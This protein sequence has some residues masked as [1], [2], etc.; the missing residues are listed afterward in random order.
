MFG[1]FR[2]GSCRAFTGASGCA[3]ASLGCWPMGDRERDFSKAGRVPIS[4]PVSSRPATATASTSYSFTSSCSKCRA[5]GHAQTFVAPEETFKSGR[6]SA[7]T[8]RFQDIPLQ[9]MEGENTKSWYTVPPSVAA[10]VNSTVTPLPMAYPSAAVPAAPTANDLMPRFL[11]APVVPSQVQAEAIRHTLQSWPMPPTLAAG[12]AAAPAPAPAAGFLQRATREAIHTKSCHVWWSDPTGDMRFRNGYNFYHQYAQ[13]DF[14]VLDRRMGTLEELRNLVNEAHAL[15]MY[16]MNHMVACPCEFGHTCVVANDYYFEGHA[17]SQATWRFHEDGGKREYKLK[18]RATQ[19]SYFH[20]M[21]WCGDALWQSFGNEP[22]GTLLNMD[23]CGDRC[24]SDP[25]CFFFLYK[26]DPGSLSTYHC[27]GFNSCSSPTPYTDGQGHVYKKWV[28]P[29]KAV[30][31]AADVWCGSHLWQ[32]Y[33]HEATG[34]LVNQDTCEAACASDASCQFYLWKDDPAANTR[35]HCAGFGTCAEADQTPFGD[36]DGS[37]IFQKRTKAERDKDGLYHTPA[38]RQP[39]ADFWYSNAWDPAAQYN[40]TLYG[41]WGESATDTGY[42]TYIESDFHHNGDLIDYHDPWEINLGKIYGVMDDLRLEQDRVQQKYIAMTKALIE[43]ADVDGYR[44]DTPMQVPLNFYKAW[45]PAMRAHAKTLG[46]DRFGI[47]GEFFVSAER[48]ATMTGRGRD[49]TMYGQDRFIDDIATLK[50]GIVYPYYWYVF[51][52]MVYQRPEYADGLP[53]AYVEENKMI[54]TY[55][56]TTNRH[57]YSMWT[58]CNN[59]DNWR[60]QS[61][62]GKPHF[63]MCLAVITFWPGVPLHYAGDEQDFDTPGSALDGWAREELSTSLAWRAVRTRESGNPADGDNFDMTHP[64]YLYIGR[65]SALRRAH[66][67][68]FGAEEC[69]EVQYPSYATP[70]VLVFLRGC[71][72][73]SKVLVFANFHTTQNR[74]ASIDALPWASGT[75]LTDCIVSHDPAEVIVS[76]GSVSVSLGPL[77]A[78]AFVENVAAVPPSITEVMPRH[79]STIDTQETNLTITLRFDRTVDSS[80]VSN[81]LLDQTSGGFTCMGDTCTREIAMASLA[82]GHHTL[83]VRAGSA[84]ADGM[85]L[86][87]SFES[88][89]LLDRQQGAISKPIHEQ[90]GLIC[91]FGRELCHNAV[92]ATLYRAQNVGGNWSEWMP[93]ASTTAWQAQLDVPVLVQYFSQLSAGFIVGDCLAS[94]GRRCHVSWHDRMFLRGELNDWGGSDEGHMMLISSYT[95]ASNITLSKFIRARFTPTNDWSKSYG[96]HPVRELLYNVPT[97]D[98][99]H[100]TFDIVPTKSGSE[101]CREWM[102]NRSLWSEHE[103]IA[104]GAEFAI[105]LWLSPFCTAA[106]PQC[107]PDPEAKWQ[108]HSYQTGQ[109]A[110][111]CASVGSEG[112]FEYSTNDQSEEMSSCVDQPVLEASFIVAVQIENMSDFEPKSN[113]IHGSLIAG[114]YGSATPNVSIADVAYMVSAEFELLNWTGALQAA[115]TEICGILTMR[116]STCSSSGAE[117]I[118]AEVRTAE[119]D[120]AGALHGLAKD[121]Q[122]MQHLLRSSSDAGGNASLRLLMPP[123]LELRLLTDVVAFASDW[124]APDLAPNVSD[125]TREFSSGYSR[126]VVLS[127]LPSPLASTTTTTLAPASSAAPNVSTTSSTVTS[128][129]SAGTNDCVDLA[130]KSAGAL[131]GNL[132]EF[133]IDGVQVEMTPGRGLSVVVLDEHGTS[134]SELHVFDTGFEAGGSAPLATLLNSLSEG[135]GVMIAA[136]DDASDNLT[137]AARNAIKQLGATQIDNLGYRGSY[138]LIGVKGRSAVAER[139]AASGE[140]HVQVS[141]RNSWKPACAD[142]TSSLA[143]AGDPIALRVRSAGAA[144]GNF[145]EFYV[146]GALVDVVAGR[147][148]TVVSLQDG[149]VETHVFDT[150]FEGLGSEGLVRFLQV[151]PYGTLVMVAAMDDATDNLTAEAK[152]AI[153]GLGASEIRSLSYRGSYALIGVQGGLALAERVASSGSGSVEIASTWIQGSGSSTTTSSSQQDQSETTTEPDGSGLSSST[154]S[155][156]ASEVAPTTLS[157]LPTQNPEVSSSTARSWEPWTKNRA[158]R[159]CLPS[160]LHA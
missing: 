12:P 7:V 87:A 157:P 78:L 58:F 85:Q 159:C 140:G 126:A 137:L 93:Y 148:L 16:V 147:G 77:Q 136:M 99:R 6:I 113:E 123:V 70:D 45:A 160:A 29:V 1:T 33:G 82:D 30:Q 112:C 47:F 24:Q 150:G 91:S 27:A 121:A 142:T 8:A 79:G 156:T 48:Y 116:N 5:G 145:V 81:V 146:N 90:P 152:A 26:N 32:E 62:T 124:Q 134:A 36:G 119:A 34:L 135:V 42:G 40:G 103:T 138:A 80:M 25:D 109:D 72:A 130:V 44:V 28:W 89:F 69:D 104:S 129:S 11:P 76:S 37:K 18:P 31:E 139:L 128:S 66:F 122:H 107:E 22:T 141:S 108:C 149:Q 97:F 10:M 73:S 4:Q 2:V 74:S 56:P 13:I 132:A 61:M 59:H 114:A 64:T 35:F 15:D 51:T 75:R 23:A 98:E 71:N 144:D 127:V 151:L 133:F 102:V 39:Y 20:G 46:K 88:V 21:V 131:D 49:N 38:G 63:V 86:H 50:G 83:E 100:R 17:M 65:L 125:L 120:D 155:S 158:I 68:N 53:L 105:D 143:N 57:E 14:T 117:V 106:A 115:A 84:T 118:R 55:D 95:W 41:Q 153:E 9:S 43:T 154:G 3:I 101:P 67:G 19:A 94:T 54:D 111:W 52:A 60:L 96:A 110:S 92:G